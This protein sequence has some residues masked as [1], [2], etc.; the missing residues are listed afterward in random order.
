MAEHEQGNGNGDGEKEKVWVPGETPPVDTLMTEELIA[1]CE[2]DTE[3]FEKAGEFDVA[4][5]LK[6]LRHRAGEKDELAGKFVQ[7]LD[8]QAAAGGAGNGAS[9]DSNPETDP[10]PDP[11]PA[12]SSGD[13]QREYI[14]L[15]RRAGAHGEESD[16]E[17]AEEGAVYSVVGVETARDGRAAAKAIYEAKFKDEENL[18]LIA[19]P[20]RMWAL[21]AI[22][23]ETKREITIG[24]A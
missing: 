7:S 13:R 22:R 19:I 14:I 11:A 12:T 17:D 1:V 10:D 2:N 6:E 20:K 21:I 24:G 9:S 3:R 5:V 8:D 23:V 16:A 18:D 4:E 15:R